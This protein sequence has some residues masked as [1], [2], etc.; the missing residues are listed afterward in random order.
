MDA[1]T[2]LVA[3][4]I[5]STIAVIGGIQWLKK[6]KSL[7]F[8]QAGSKVISRF[9]SIVAAFFVTVGIHYTWSTNP[10]GT[11]TLIL[12]NINFMVIVIALFHVTEQFLYQETG[13]QALQG[14]QAVQGI[15]NFLQ[16]AAPAIPVAPTPEPVTSSSAP[17]PNNP[18][19]KAAS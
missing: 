18:P 6:I 2:S 9:V 19:I 4:H 12:A 16:S 13:Y 8:I 7:T 17:A 15:L 11:H 1:D 3:T 14:I 10:D 5:G